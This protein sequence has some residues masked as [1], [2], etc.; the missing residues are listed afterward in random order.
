MLT[1]EPP[2]GRQS[3]FLAALMTRL[4]YISL[5]SGCLAGM[6]LPRAASDLI[7]SPTVLCRNLVCSPAVTPP[8]G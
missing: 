4:I 2:Q 7:P 1:S 3:I 5:G 6:G 8:Q